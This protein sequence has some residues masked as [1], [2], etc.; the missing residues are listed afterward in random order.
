MP[1]S[2]KFQGIW[3]IKMVLSGSITQAI[4]QNKTN[5]L[6][7]EARSRKWKKSK[8]QSRSIN[9]NQKASKNK[10]RLDLKYEEDNTPLLHQVAAHLLLRSSAMWVVMCFTMI[11][12][13]S[14]ESCRLRKNITL[15]GLNQSRHPQRR[16]LK[17]SSLTWSFCMVSPRLAIIARAVLSCKARKA[18][19]RDNHRLVKAVHL[20]AMGATLSAPTKRVE[21]SVSIYKNARIR[22]IWLVITRLFT[23]LKRHG[24][25][26]VRTNSNIYSL[27]K[28]CQTCRKTPILEITMRCIHKPNQVMI[29]DQWLVVRMEIVNT[30]F[31]LR[32]LQ[33]CVLKTSQRTR[34]LRQPLKCNLIRSQVRVPP[35]LNTRLSGST[36]R[37]KT[38]N[39]SEKP[40]IKTI[41][42]LIRIIAGSNRWRAIWPC[43]RVN[44][45]SLCPP[46]CT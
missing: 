12:I 37:L 2:L 32:N 30:T 21:H 7:G 3:M 33:L 29:H 43:R 27:M 42:N 8:M 31:G 36:S 13:S 39:R 23:D 17:P 19:V 18:P 4:Q 45:L 41:S 24:R 5:S 26:R 44:F 35:H 15:Q 1:L 6:C 9:K 28:K 10:N 14:I 16:P 40:S 46:A 22:I 34:H 20:T 38:Q 11:T 25:Q